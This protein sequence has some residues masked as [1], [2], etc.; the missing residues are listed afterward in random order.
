MNC[1]ICDCIY[2]DNNH[3]KEHLMSITHQ[4]NE[5]NQ[6]LEA[7]INKDDSTYLEREGIISD[8]KCLEE[9][10]QFECAK[11][12]KVTT[13]IKDMILHENHCINVEVNHTI[14]SHKVLSCD[15]CGYKIYERGQKF[16]PE[17]MMN[18][19]KTVCVQRKRKRQ[20]KAIKDSLNTLDKSVVDEIFKLISN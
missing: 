12:S 2:K 7:R 4:T 19:H 9:D 20:I 14:L 5:Y 10:T 16:K 18:R 1:S 17:Y 11:C 13:S 3:K 15:E 8:Y 6:A